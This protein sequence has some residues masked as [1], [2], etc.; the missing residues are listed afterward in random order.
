MKTVLYSWK[1][2]QTQITCSCT[3]QSR[4]RIWGFMNTMNYQMK[5]QQNR[6]EKKAVKVM[7]C[8]KAQYLILLC[9]ISGDVTVF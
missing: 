7:A 4:N 6:L 2:I 8:L 3:C 1:I 5:G 9:F